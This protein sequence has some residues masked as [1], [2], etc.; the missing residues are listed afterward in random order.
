MLTER[1][2]KILTALKEDPTL[3]VRALAQML[4]VSEPTVRRDLT[5]LSEKGFL[6]KHYG[7]ASVTPAAAD[8]E[9]PFLLRAE[10]KSDA[11]TEIARR[12]AALV[13][14]G[15]VIMLDGSTSAFR[16]VPFLKDKKDIICITSGARTSVALAEAGIKNFSTGGQ[17]VVNSFSFVGAEAEH[18]VST[19][20]ADIE[21]MMHSVV[22]MCTSVPR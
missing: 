2:E 13:E 3:S 9:I 16:L 6:T 22:P 4:Y 10:E 7:G 14:D 5:A 11:K 15:M 18:F 1:Q 20:S 19:V 8:T 12:A 21:L 17:M